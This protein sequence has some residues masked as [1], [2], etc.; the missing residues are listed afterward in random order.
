MSSC[1]II[2]AYQPDEILLKLVDQL[3]SY[4][5][6]IIVVDDGSGEAY[7]PVFEKIEDVCIVLRH[8]QNRGKGAAIKTALSYIKQETW[9]CACIGVMDA[10]GQHLVTDMLRLLK[11]SAGRPNTLVLGTREFG[12]NTQRAAHEC[13]VPLRSRL[14]NAAA[15]VVFRLLSGKWVSDTQTGLRA[16]GAGLVTKLL[17]VDGDRYE[18]EMNVL[19]ECVK[20]GVPIR[21]VPIAV[22]YHDKTNSCSH[23]KPLA[24]SL[25][26]S[27]NMLKFTLSSLSS[28]FL[29]YLA[30]WALM[31]L[32]PHTPPAVLFANVAARLGS[33]LYNYELNCRVVFLEREKPQTAVS[34]AALAAAVLVLNSAILQLLTLGAGMS[35]YPA[36]LL[37]ELLLF[38][39]SFS[40]QNFWIF[41]KNRDGHKEALRV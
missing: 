41:R 36:K 17:A 38:L 34:Y 27:G 35:V 31:F 16:F 1:V 3:W 24:D 39:L 19:L 25:R 40:V 32:L 15:C 28:F 2:P 13:G 10:D 29:D 14:G 4:G 11:V 33:A 21:E 37:T 9:D 8:E 18:Y 7:Q 12:T 30:F 5:C 20:T 26:I 22:I 6:S 23:F